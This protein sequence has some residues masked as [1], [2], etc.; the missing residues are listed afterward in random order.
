MNG[1]MRS[2]LYLLLIAG[3]S[4]LG[5]QVEIQEDLLAPWCLVETVLSQ[6]VLHMFGVPVER[7][8]AVLMDPASGRSIVVLWPCSGAD[9][10][11]ILLATILVFRSDWRSKVMGLLGGFVAI[12]GMNVLRI[13]SLFYLLIIH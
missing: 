11:F 1:M 3:G 8:G 5:S 13:I 9:A 7:L 4:V 6:S 12:Q 2:L 10:T